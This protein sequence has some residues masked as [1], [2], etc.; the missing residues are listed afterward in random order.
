MTNSTEGSRGTQFVSQN[1]AQLHL[2]RLTF[3][4][5]VS[6]RLAEIA[7][8]WS[9]IACFFFFLLLWIAFNR[10]VP[11]SDR[12]DSYPFILLNLVLSCLAAIQAPVILMSVNRQE[13]R[14]RLRDEQDFQ[15]NLKAEREITDIQQDLDHLRQELAG[16]VQLGQE[17]TDLLRELPERIRIAGR[18]G[19]SGTD[20]ASGGPDIL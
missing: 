10:T 2:T 14:D 12:F 6:D 16:I 13:A 11:P 18:N 17:A 19:T 9:F 15:V 3:G 5:R 4:Q 20:A 7:G 8:S 1:V